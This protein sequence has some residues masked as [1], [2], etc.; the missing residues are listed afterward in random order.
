MRKNL[1]QPVTTVDAQTIAPSL[2]K[3][4][5]K[6]Q[7]CQ[8]KLKFGTYSN[9][10]M[11]NSVV[12]FTFSVLHGK[13]LFLLFLQ[14]CGSRDLRL[15]CRQHGFFILLQWVPPWIAFVHSLNVLK[16]L[17]LKQTFYFTWINFL[18]EKLYKL[19]NLDW[20]FHVTWTNLFLM[21]HKLINF[22]WIINN[23]IARIINLLINY[24]DLI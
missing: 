23:V 13:R 9:S 7:R 2:G 1:I 11:Q 12:V 3:S 22:D 8:F 6:N 15:S 17:K 20:I 24:L 21:K 4:G 5:P 14:P 10:N 19:S 18:L 16:H